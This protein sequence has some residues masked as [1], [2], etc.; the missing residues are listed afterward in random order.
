MRVCPSNAGH[1]G[2]VFVLL[3]RI[4]LS[5]AQVSLDPSGNEGSWFY[6]FPFY[7]VIKIHAHCTFCVS[8]IMSIK[9]LE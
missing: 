2:G 4:S 6:M 5:C 1:G 7:K 3:N 8:Y 9:R